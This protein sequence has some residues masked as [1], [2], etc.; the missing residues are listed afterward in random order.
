M[1]RLLISKK[2]VSCLSV[3]FLIS[4]S[5]MVCSYKYE[6]DA[7]ASSE[8]FK[9]E[10]NANPPVHSCHD[11]QSSRKTSSS[12][13]NNQPDSACPIC[14]A[15]TCYQV[16]STLLNNKEIPSEKKPSQTTSSPNH[17]FIAGHTSL[18]NTTSNKASTSTSLLK[19]T[20]L[21]KIYKNIQS[22][23]MVFRN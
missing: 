14:T 8:I 23:L 16:F 11:P 7:H 2:L 12:Q 1:S 13:H 9:N 17:F 22:Y 20:P 3:I 5:I 15:E 4:S 18:K 21:F 6:L 19:G 10:T